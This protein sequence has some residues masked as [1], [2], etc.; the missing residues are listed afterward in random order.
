ME[1]FF[2]QSLKR[3]L[4]ILQK[5]EKMMTN[6]LLKKGIEGLNEHFIKI[7]T[8][9]VEVGI[10]RCTFEVKRFRQSSVHHW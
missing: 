2:L 8:N 7:A 9:S 6:Y 1:K 5:I 10:K 3:L 4:K